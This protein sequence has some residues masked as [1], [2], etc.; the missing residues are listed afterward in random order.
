M[1]LG[2]AAWLCHGHA[3]S[4]P[5]S[6]LPARTPS[7]TRDV[8]DEERGLANRNHGFPLELLRHDITPTGA[9][10]LL[11]HFDMPYL[12]EASYQLTIGGAV[13]RPVTLTL[14]D[15][16]ALPQVDVP[17]TLEC[18]GNGRAGHDPRHRSMPWLYEA[19]GTSIWQGT[20]LLPLLE[21]A[22]AMD[23]VQDW[24]FIGADV[25]F[26]DGVRH[27]FGR[28]LTPAEVQEL[29]PLVVTGMNG[30]P[31]LPQHGAPVRLIVPGWYGM[32]SV[33]WLTRIEALTERYEGYQQVRTYRYRKDAN[34]PGHPGQAIRIK[35]LMVPPGEPDWY[36][37]RRWLP[38]GP[39]T[40]EGRAWVG[41]GRHVAGVTVMAGETILPTTLSD[42]VGPDA[43]VK[44]STTWE[45]TPGNH[46]LR[47][48]ARDNRGDEQPLTPPQD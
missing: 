18:A 23:G 35:S 42:P 10:Y 13:R 16:R 2:G 26:D 7:P 36:S 43:W 48:I 38:P 37:R 28:A 24:S 22:G 25:G 30:A 11:T 29:Q 15:L 3:R 4:A 5:F 41:H 34:D 31:L 8:A 46:V 12:P 32:A 40:L 14:S 9:H 20:P 39:V 33:K 47:P 19:V 21:Q 17:V 1:G 27:H 6:D 44:W 45:A